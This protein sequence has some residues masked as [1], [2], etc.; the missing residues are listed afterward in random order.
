MEQL[1]HGSNEKVIL[2]RTIKYNT[3]VY[4]ITDNHEKTPDEL[5]NNHH[6]DDVCLTRLIPMVL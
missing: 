5:M 6:D 2:K 3:S 4:F 1:S